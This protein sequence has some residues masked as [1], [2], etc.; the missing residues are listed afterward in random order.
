MHISTKYKKDR[1]QVP[2]FGS[3][4]LLDKKTTADNIGHCSACVGLRKNLHRRLV[5]NQ[6]RLV[7]LKFKVKA[8]IQQRFVHGVSVHPII[9]IFL[10]HAPIPLKKN[11]L[12]RYSFSY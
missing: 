7:L 10:R 12:K 2:F 9:I 6:R 8:D 11:K 1:N 5:F 3:Q 4:Q